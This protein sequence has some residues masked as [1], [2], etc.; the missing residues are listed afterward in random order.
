MKNY[1]ITLPNKFLEGKILENN[2]QYF[3][4]YLF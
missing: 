4:E 2:F 1:K 3:V